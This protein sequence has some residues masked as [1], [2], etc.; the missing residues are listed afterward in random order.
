MEALLHLLERVNEWTGRIFGW[1]AAVLTLIVVL[2]VILRYGF[3][4]PT[5][6]NFEITKQIY[7]FYFMIVSG[8]ALLHGAH[9]S[10]DVI[11]SKLAQRKRDVLDIISYILFFFPF[12]GIVLLY[13]TRFATDSWEI[14]ETS[15]SACGSPLYYIKTIVPLSFVLII[16]QG[17]AL[18]ARTLRRL[19]KGDYHAGP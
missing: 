5:V 17:I 18:F 9:V 3:N 2:E 12:C 10:V 8:Y 6:C 19:I 16:I 13:G 7:G 4:S 1:T 11:H 15:W 14:L